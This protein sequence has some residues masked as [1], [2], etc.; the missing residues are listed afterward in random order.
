MQGYK[1]LS[2]TADW[3]ISVW[4]DDLNGLFSESAAAMY[5]LMGVKLNESGLQSR[6]LSLHSDDTEC[7]LVAYLSELLFI[8]ETEDLIAAGQEITVSSKSLEGEILLLP[9]HNLGKEIKAVTFSGMN[10]RSTEQGVQVEI[11]FDV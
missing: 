3:S 11:V 6:S 4:A 7:L 5:S 10:I 1:E 8:M 2:H 9:L